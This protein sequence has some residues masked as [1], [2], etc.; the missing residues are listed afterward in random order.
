MKSSLSDSEVCGPELKDL[1][2]GSIRSVSPFLQFL[3]K[4]LG[5]S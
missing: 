4:A 3:A 2:L 5:E 1:V